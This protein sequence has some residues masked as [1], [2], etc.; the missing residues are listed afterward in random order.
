MERHLRDAEGHG[1]DPPERRRHGLRVQPAAAGGRHRG[2]H[3]RRRERAGLVHARLRRGDGVDQA[4]RHAARREHGDPVASITRTS[5]RSST[6]KS[7]MTTLQNFNITVAVTRSASC[8][9]SSAA[10][11]TSWSTRARGKVAR[12]A[13]RARRSSGRSSRT[14][15]RTAIP[16]SSSSTGSTA[17]TRRRSSGAIEATNP[18]GEQPLLPYES[19]NLGSINLAKFV[20][21]RTRGRARARSGGTAHRAPRRHRLG[22]ARRGDPGLRA[23]PRR[24]D[25]AEP[26]P[27]PG[28]RR[29]DEADAQDRPGRDGLGR[30]AVPAAHPVRLATRRSSWPGA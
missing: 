24:R 13:R 21:A 7:D 18:C 15:G 1:A 11:S 9:P 5:R 14:P 20:R 27:D 3:G 23:L 8:R 10:R 17:T 22:R 29:D 30:P 26:L 12:Q 19:C 16:G 25:R 28:D 4:G 2:A 6:C